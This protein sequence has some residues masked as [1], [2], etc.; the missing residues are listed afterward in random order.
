MRPK[1]EFDE[2]QIRSQHNF[3]AFP[4]KG[5]LLFN[6]SVRSDP[7][8]L[9]KIMAHIHIP[10]CSG[11][12]FKEKLCKVA[13]ND[14]RHFPGCADFSH[15]PGC[16]PPEWSPTHCGYDEV[17]DCLRRGMARDLTK[18]NRL[19]APFPA[20]QPHQRPLFATVLRDPVERVISEFYWWKGTAPHKNCTRHPQWGKELCQAAQKGIEA[21]VRSPYNIAHNRQARYF[22]A[23]NDIAPGNKSYHIVTQKEEP[24]W[25]CTTFHASYTNH[26]WSK[27]YGTNAGGWGTRL[28]R[29]EAVADRVIKVLEERFWFVGLLEDYP[30]NVPFFSHL[31]D[32]LV[33]GQHPKKLRTSLLKNGQV[34]KTNS[35]RKQPVSDELKAEIRDRNRL[36][37]KIFKYIVLRFYDAASKVIPGY[38]L[39]S[40][41]D[42]NSGVKQQ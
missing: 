32:A 24:Q 35:A 11:H 38:S 23:K 31:V 2:K 19:G 29:D 36:D 5:S 15:S 33:G 42:Q 10:K 12:D 13:K 37:D 25:E 17:D 4:E 28:N 8:V 34:K 14:F 26:Y 22:A 3:P 40:K 39:E 18:G 30:T 7:D 9:T 1:Y 20:V 21:W 41:N 6:T 27:E 16:G